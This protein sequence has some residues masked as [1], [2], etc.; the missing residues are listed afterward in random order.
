MR[1]FKSFR[2]LHRRTKSEGDVITVLTTQSATQTTGGIF[3]VQHPSHQGLL[4]VTYESSSLFVDSV[5]FTPPKH[6]LPIFDPVDLYAPFPYATPPRLLEPS[7]E[8]MIAELEAELTT[9]RAA[10]RTLKADLVEIAKEAADAR[11]ALY[12]EMTK[13]AHLKHQ[14]MVDTQRFQIFTAAFAK[15]KTID[16]LLARIGLD[17]AVLEEALATL[18]DGGKAEDVVMDAIKRASARADCAPSGT[19]TIGP[20]TPEQYAAVLNMTLRVRKELKGNKKLTKFWKRVAQRDGKHQDT[21]TPSPSDISSIHEQLSPERQKAVEEVAARRREISTRILKD[22]S[23]DSAAQNTAIPSATRFADVKNDPS[24]VARASMAIAPDM[25]S[26]VYADVFTA[27]PPLASESIKLELAQHSR[28]KRF[29]GSRPSKK[30]SV[31]RPVDL[32]VQQTS[33]TPELILRT[34][35]PERRQTAPVSYDQYT[36]LKLY[37][38]QCWRNILG[39]TLISPPPFVIC[40]WDQLRTDQ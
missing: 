24:D 8:S 40:F 25:S 36:A 35:I 32:N 18:E 37:L 28:S 33:T 6:P 4:D 9:L 7:P 39:G 21:I 26:T 38:T 10:N 23:L 3:P 31:L 14:A 16:G 5:S 29:S 2:L 30:G 12:A 34:H 20:R 22:S 27:L 17:K 1:F 13:N 19:A 15:Y 11:A